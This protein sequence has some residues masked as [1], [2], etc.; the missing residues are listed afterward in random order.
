L[1]GN[2]WEWVNSL[3]MDYPYDPDDGREVDGDSDSSSNR[4]LRDG[5]WGDDSSLVRAAYR[6][7]NTPVNSRDNGGFRCARS[8]APPNAIPPD[9][10]TPTA[11]P[12]SAE[13]RA[14][15]GVAANSDWN[16]YFQ[17]FD[18][19]K[20]ALVPAGCFMMGSDTDSSRRPVHEQCFDEPFWIDV[21][22]VTNAQF[23]EFGGEAE[24]DSS[25]TEDNLPR[26]QI[27][28]AEALAFCERRG[29]RLPTEVEWEYA[30]R[31]PDGL[32]YP[33]GNAFD[34]SRGNFDD[35]AAVH[36]TDTV[37]GGPDCDGAAMTTTVGSFPYGVSWVG[38]FDMSG[39]ISEWMSSWFAPYPYDPTDGREA[40]N[41]PG[42]YEYRVLRG[43]S[44]AHD[45]I[46]HLNNTY[47]FTTDPT[48]PSVFDGLRCARS[49][50]D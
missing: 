40:Q 48:I 19:V 20:M 44:W 1:S 49:Y 14:F 42:G 13:D 46:D 4:V 23:R 45:S 3:Y 16:P 21:Y 30:A 39:N 43:G 41:N 15:A 36:D 31:G 22:E 47:R 37:P 35:E 5:S 33:W 11:A 12:E 34:C 26:D 7:R 28:W 50:G 17:E 25:S 2:I 27:T 8:Y 6:G 9:Q 18:G 24:S 10:P 38:A 29:A 32:M